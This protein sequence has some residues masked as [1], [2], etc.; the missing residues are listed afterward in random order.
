[1]TAPQIRLYIAVSVDGFIAPPDGSSNWLA[2]YD[3]NQYG[4]AEFIAG[5][6]TVVMG[7][8]SYE[9]ALGLGDWPWPGRR[10]VVLTSRRIAPPPEAELEVASGEVEG[11][12][13][14]LKQESAG[15]IWL[16]GG[17]KAARPFLAAGLVDRL[18]LFQIPVLLGDGIRLF[19]PG[20]PPHR[21]RLER[22]AAHAKGVVELIYASSSAP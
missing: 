8:A 13:A 18:E 19:E 20:L 16:L 9:E 6:S 11:L 3:A 22:T 7:R 21:L 5:V 14:R 4:Y 15:D 2:D 17:A 1:M 12:A 10:C